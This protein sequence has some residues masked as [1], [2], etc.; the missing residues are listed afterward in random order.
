MIESKGSVK[1][2]YRGLLNIFDIC[3]GGYSITVTIL[4]FISAQQGRSHWTTFYLLLLFV[5][6]N[7]ILSQISQRVKK[8]YRVEIFRVF[9]ANTIIVPLISIYSDGPFQNYWPTYLIMGLAGGVFLTTWHQNRKWP[10]LG[11]MFW[12]ASF[13][14]V[15][16]ALDDNGGPW[17]VFLMYAGIILM[18]A[19]LTIELMITIN[20]SLQKELLARAQ[21]NQVTKL[22]A[23]GEMA[24]G[25][26]HEINTPLASIKNLSS[27]I[28]EL[29]QENPIDRAILI[30]MAS[31]LSVSTD[32]VAKIIV[33]LRAFSRDGSRDAFALVDL[34]KVINDTLDLCKERF[35]QSDVE[36]IVEH[37]NSDLH[38]YGRF[39]ELCQV[40]LNL[41][42]N[43]F[44]AV[45]NLQEKWIQIQINSQTTGVVMRITNSGPL[46]SK[47]AQ[48]HLFQPFFTTKEIGKGTGLGLSISL[49][50][51]KNHGGTLAFDNN[52]GHTCFEVSL[53][54]PPNEKKG[55]VA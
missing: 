38:I 40:L 8:Q 28:G 9:V 53:P 39:T 4:S 3:F 55:A 31:A 22:A 2:K 36:L 52:A 32:R 15:N 12:V 18:A 29:L 43:A 50:I 11:V 47:E 16:F 42:N 45:E 35:K 20:K 13:G 26:A 27:Q 41:L 5:G 7:L 37:P 54:K 6:V 10:Y 19:S 48:Q 25:I 51:V 17:E 14:I 46:I 24:S 1:N 30:E 23:L 34:V 33:G 44:D 49:G 21:A